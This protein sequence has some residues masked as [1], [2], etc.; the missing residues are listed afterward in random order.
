MV[1]IYVLSFL[2]HN[3]FYHSILCCLGFEVDNL[4]LFTFY[5]GLEKKS[6]IGL[7]FD[8]MKNNHDIE[9]IKIETKK[10]WEPFFYIY[11]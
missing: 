9:G 10:K 4:F 2:G 11:I 3:F 5:Y 8:F 7:V 6:Y 1:S